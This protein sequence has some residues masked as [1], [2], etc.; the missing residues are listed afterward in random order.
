MSLSHAQYALADFEAAAD[1]FERG[2]KIDPSNAS[3][4]AALASAQ[5]RITETSTDSLDTTAAQPTPQMPAGLGGMADL[6]RGMGGAGGAGGGMP[7]LA[8]MM[9]NPQLMAMAQQLASNGGL[10]NMMQNPAVANMVCSISLSMSSANKFLD[11]SCP[12]G[13]HALYGRVTG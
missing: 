4:K 1:A 7:D 2:L 3:L 13:K 5:T 10:A 11:E 8:S 9:N 12:A 6:L